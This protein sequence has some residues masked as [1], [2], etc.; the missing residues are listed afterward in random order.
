MCLGGS[1]LN[2]GQTLEMRRGSGNATNL[3]N[4]CG[5]TTSLT[6]V[7]NKNP[8][9]GWV[10]F[11]G[12]TLKVTADTTSL[13]ENTLTGVYSFGA[14][15][16][17]AGGAVV[18]TDSHNVTMTKPI[19][20]PAGNGVYG[21]SLSSQGSGYVGEPY[22]SITGGGG[23]G[24]AAVAEMVD[25]GSGNG[26]YKVGSIV[27]TSPGTGYT[28]AP[29]VTLIRGGGDAVA[30][31]V[32]TVTIAP[33][34]SGGM[35]KLGSGTLTLTA[36]NTYTGTTKVSGGELVLNNAAALASG[37][38]VVLDGGTLDLNG[39]SVTNDLNGTGTVTDGSMHT[40]ISPAGEGAIGSD[41]ITLLSATIEGEYIADV[42]SSGDSDFVQI[43]GGIN[44]N[45]MKFEVVDTHQ[46]NMDHT[47]TVMKAPGSAGKMT[48]LNLPDSR[49][50][51]VYHSDGTVNLAFV[52]GTVMIVR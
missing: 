26:T 6:R 36:A 29:T 24:A 14:H 50:H 13:I 9:I 45:N 33:N 20:A 40:V 31:I 12:G 46:L 11:S 32:D 51:L 23:S 37:S 4:L 5:G 19:E 21:V 17:F 44:L 35:T 49:W 41:A 22:V 7:L 2:D 48:A 47:Y 25:D 30:A 52:S 27:I 43:N 3:L 16:T 38:E 18:D 28:S 39:Y 1:L 10:N 42:T 15:G 8:G 34:A